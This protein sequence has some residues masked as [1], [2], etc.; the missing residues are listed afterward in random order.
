MISL[1]GKYN[2]LQLKNHT[3]GKEPQ[4]FEVKKIA[5]SGHKKGAGRKQPAPINI[6]YK[7]FTQLSLWKE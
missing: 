7:T 2:L 1:A 5:L 3:E 4:T 6:Q